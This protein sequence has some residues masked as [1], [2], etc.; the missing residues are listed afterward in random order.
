MVAIEKIQSMCIFLQDAC[1]HD[2]LR[3]SRGTHLHQIVVWP[4]LDYNNYPSTNTQLG[5]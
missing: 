4:H 3:K 5:G 1:T 2:T